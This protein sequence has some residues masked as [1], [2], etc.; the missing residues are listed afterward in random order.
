MPK[1]LERARE[2]GQFMNQGALYMGFVGL[3]IS[4]PHCRYSDQ[5]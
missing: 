5:L 2:Q 1:W 3:H 4:L